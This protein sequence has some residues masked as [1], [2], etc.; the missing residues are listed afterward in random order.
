MAPSGLPTL[1]Q[2]VENVQRPNARQEYSEALTVLGSQG[3]L[4]NLAGGSLAAKNIWGSTFRMFMGITDE[5][6]GVTEIENNATG[7]ARAL[8]AEPYVNRCLTYRGNAIGSIPLRCYQVDSEGKVLKAVDHDALALLE[9]TNPIE[10]DWIATAPQL[11]EYSL[12]S[13]D[14]NGHMAWQVATSKTGKPTELYFLLPTQ[15]DIH[16]DAETGW[17]GLTVTRKSKDGGSQVDVIPRGRVVY[18]A[19]K[20]L[21]DPLRGTSRIEVLRDMINLILYAYESNKSYFKNSQ[22]P[23]WVLTGDFSNS[24]D[25]VNR[26]R[27]TLRKWLSGEN[28]RSPLVLGDKA[29]AHLLTTAT[30]DMEWLNQ[31]RVGS[32]IISMCF[33]IPVPI[34]NNFE[35]S[36]YENLQAARIAFWADNFIPEMDGFTTRLT[37]A[38][39]RKFWPETQ[40]QRLILGFDYTKIEGISEDMAKAWERIKGMWLAFTEDVKLYTITPNEARVLK[41][42]LLAQAGLSSQALKGSLKYGGDD[43]YGSYMD[44]PLSEH[45]TQALI[46]VMAARGTNPQLEENVPGAPHAG[47]NAKKPP[48][49]PAP[50]PQSSKALSL[51]DVKGLISEAMAAAPSLIVQKGPSPLPIRDARLAKPQADLMRG[52]KR[53]FQ[54]QKNEALRN[55]RNSAGVA[56]QIADEGLTVKL[57]NPHDSL[58]DQEKYTQRLLELIEQGILDSAEVA[59]GAS[60]QEYGLP[61]NFD[62]DHSRIVGYVGQ[63]ADLIRGIDDTTRDS[64][65]SQLTEGV[66]AGDTMPQLAQRVSSVFATAIDSRAEKIARTETIQAYGFASLASYAD[67]GIE[68]AQMY[69]GSGDPECAAV[70]GQIVSIAEAEQLMASEH[71]NGTRGVAPVVNLPIAASAPSANIIVRKQYAPEKSPRPAQHRHDYGQNT[72]PVLAFDLHHTLTPDIGYPLVSDP[73]PGIKE[74]MDQFA[75]RG[76]CLHLCSASLDFPDQ[77]I[78]AARTGQVYA[79]LAKNGLPVSFVGPNA[80]A[81]LRIDDRGIQVP[82]T[83]DWPSLWALAEK[84]LAKT[85][86]VDKAGKYQRREDLT[87]VG[88]VLDDQE[89][90]DD[91]DVPPDQPRGFTTPLIDIDMHRTLMPAWGTSRDAKP[92]PDGA[93]CMREWYQKG[94]TLQVS[95]AGWNP[96]LADNPEVAAAKGAW[97]RQ[98]LRKYGIPYDRLVT[99]DDYDVWFDDRVVPYNGDWAAVDAAIEAAYGDQIRSWPAA[100]VGDLPSAPIKSHGL[101]PADVRRNIALLKAKLQ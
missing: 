55:L 18:M 39:L 53:L 54:D 33:G 49:A 25:N 73:F 80:E 50:T 35:R 38:Y 34:V 37:R 24:E 15:Y 46:D 23:D 69:D 1:Q 13:L 21:L 10:I 9:S 3:A 71:P 67:A 100:A 30:K 90:P 2:L 40:R 42:E 84:K 88:R 59:Y 91:G 14:T 4:K 47:D 61:V 48:P 65:I 22:R 27:R 93:R 97:Q 99:K 56:M 64:V 17:D 28:N 82:E 94:Y 57:L 68:K 52:L 12:G 101:S 36:T 63:R 86:Q 32:E 85:Y 79:F 78:D 41:S 16:P 83:P 74:G 92:N 89:F 96:A 72:M 58:W 95:C 6:T 20:S 45:S 98:Y 29:Q 70:D 8:V 51:D 44:T 7:W 62:R 75:A 11:L 43:F 66:Q 77:D 26:I 87:P 60:A 19:T 31:I 5:G 81:S 76:C